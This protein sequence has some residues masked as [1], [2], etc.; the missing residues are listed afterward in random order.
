MGILQ[1]CFSCF[2]S[3]KMRNCFLQKENKAPNKLLEDGFSDSFIPLSRSPTARLG[4]AHLGRQPDA[5]SSLS[6]INTALKLLMVSIALQNMV[7]PDGFMRLEQLT[8]D[9]IAPGSGAHPCSLWARRSL[10]VPEA[11]P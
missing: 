5:F 11:D 3:F 7:R 6:A 1:A 2:A 10:L 9:F 8:P 4:D